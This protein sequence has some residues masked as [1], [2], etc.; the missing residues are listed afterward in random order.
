MQDI[1]ITYGALVVAALIRLVVAAL[2]FSPLAFLESW[3]KVVGIDE[4][5]MNAGMPRAI[6][7]DVVGS[8]IMAFVLVHAVVYAGAATLGQ[9][10]AVGFFNWLGLVAVVQLSE[11]MHENRP[12][13]FFAISTGYNFIALILMGAL[14]AVWR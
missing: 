5:T 2:W 9:G 8:L 6:A 14:L 4:K 12:L 3:R 13:R 11:T 7:L 10:A 1:A